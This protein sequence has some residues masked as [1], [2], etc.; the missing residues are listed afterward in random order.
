VRETRLHQGPATEK[1]LKALIWKIDRFATHDG[2]G[3]R[4]NIYF[5][6]CPM[7]CLWC[8]NPEGQKKKIELGL[9]QTKCTE[10]GLCYS[11][12]PQGAIELQN[13]VPSVDSMKC[14]LCKKCLKECP[15][16]AFFVFGKYYTL[17]QILDLFERDRYIYRSSGGGITCT[18]GEPLM[19]A[20]SVRRLLAKCHEVGIHTTVE[21]CG[22]VSNI[23]FQQS[24]GDIDWL[25]FDLKHVDS[26][27]HKKLTG[28]DNAVILNNL[29]TASSVFSEKGGALIIR[30][31][32]VPGLNTDNIKALAELAS[33][34]PHV[35]GIEL[36]PYNSYGAHKYTLLGRKYQLGNLALPSGDELHE[37]REIVKS[38]GI[39][40][41]VGEL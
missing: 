40:C 5:K 7:R 25:F 6:G 23:E 15:A 28:K 14:N 24:L 36:L 2:P 41:D 31:V 38:Y 35:D 8:S 39:K 26:T 1:D 22:Y 17:P 27:K 4:T 37:Y 11:S 21:T 32:V 3:I 19:Q 34:L 33:T 13:G 16:G 10:C 18:G 20:K 12:C 30:Q 9:S 29:R